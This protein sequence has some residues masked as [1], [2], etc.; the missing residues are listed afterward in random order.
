LLTKYSLPFFKT[1][2]QY[3]T[4]RSASLITQHYNDYHDVGI[5]DVTQRIIN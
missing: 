1:E 3:L 4:F 2:N 5:K